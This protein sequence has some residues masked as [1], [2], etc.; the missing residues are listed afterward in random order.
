MFNVKFIFSKFS[1][2]RVV[3]FRFRPAF[4]HG[5]ISIFIVANTRQI[6]AR[7]FKCRNVRITVTLTEI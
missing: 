4:S 3:T 1:R 7:L 2:I 5:F 6:F